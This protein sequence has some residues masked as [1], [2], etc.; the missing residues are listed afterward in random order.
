MKDKESAKKEFLSEAEELLEELTTGLQQLEESLKNNKIRPDLI[1]KLFREFHSLKGISGMLGF[2]GISNFTHELENMLDHLRLG[3]MEL[4]EK[5]V[6]LLF[7]AIDLLNKMLA[8]I[9]E[10]SKEKVDPSSL[11]RTIGQMMAAGVTAPEAGAFPELNLDEQTILS[12]TEYEEH[13]L[14]ENIRNRQH[15]YSI[16]LL[17]N[18]STFDRELREINDRLSRHGEII[19]TLPYFDVAAGPDTM[20]FRLI[21][22]SEQSPEAL[23]QHLNRADV[24]ISNIGKG[25]ERQIVPP[26]PGEELKEQETAAEDTLR[27]ISNTVRVDI[28]KLDDVIN[29][30][31]ELVISKTM[32]SNLS[33]ELMAAGSTSRYGVAL[34]RA[35]AELEKKLN[36]LQHRVIETRLVPV[37][38]LYHRL[39]RMVRKISRETGKTVQIE[40]FGE[41]TELD[42]IM[43]EQISDPLM[44]VVRNAIDHGIES[45]EERRR[46]GKPEQGLIKVSAFQRGNNVVIQ[47][48]DDGRGIQ[49]Y[50]VQEHARRR[51]LIPK[52]RVLDQT[53]TLEII[54]APGFSSTDKVTELSG[55]GVGLDVVKRNI[56]ELKGSISVFTEE[57][58]GSVF[59]ITLPIT[60][61]IIQAL[62]V[63]IGQVKYA[64]PLS[65]VAETVRI[66]SRDIQ[67]VDRKEVYYLRNRTIPLILVDQFFDLPRNG[68]RQKAFVIVIQMAEQFFGLV[69]DELVGQQEIIIK[70]MGDK[71][72]NVPGIAGAT[73]IGERKPILVLDAESMIEEVT[74]GK[75]RGL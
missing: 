57:N 22:G 1:N 11:V 41:G 73:E 58:R 16:R 65:S 5:T 27:S 38:Q 74:H 45:K 13:R 63:R 42:K 6:D 3:K 54:F 7:Q 66:F 60:L 64:V 39:A 52:D 56:A 40:F 46:A 47:V 44:H 25:R 37:G 71:L 49:V 32:I 61:A 15:I 59:E 35:A 8:A 68:S 18:N 10:N 69:V 48:Q 34:S 20:L 36:D 26:Q 31:G 50:R 12:F 23:L 51:G 17:L 21:Y 33:R 30:I 28:Q 9:K 19:S 75:I 24:E 70:S 29:V 14:R 2:D 67:T 55:R 72:K 43:I 62:I 53:E 4:R